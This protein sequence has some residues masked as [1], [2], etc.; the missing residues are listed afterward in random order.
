MNAYFYLLRLNRPLPILIILWPTLWAL[1]SA[2]SDFP[3]VKIIFIFVM[4]VLLMRTAGCVFNDIADRKFDAQVKRTEH[5]VIATGVV[6]VKSAAIVGILLLLCAFSLVLFL[7]QFT[8]F[9][10]VVGLLLALTYPFFKRFFMLPQ[11]VLGCAFN[12]GVIMAY[13]ARTNSIS[14]EAW[15]MYLACILWTLAYD[16]MYALADKPYDI[17]LGLKSS[18]I[19]FGRYIGKIIAASQALMLILLA[20]FGY[21]NGYNRWFYMALIVCIILFYCQYQFWR[22]QTIAGCIRAFSDNHW[23]GLVVFIAILLQG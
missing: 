14:F 21:C 8:I 16:T 10:S 17:K 5:R 2:G 3:S 23:V 4:G 12:F 7:N 19:T 20:E 22:S 11:L 6:S 15:L 9:L 13:A 1:F 18:A